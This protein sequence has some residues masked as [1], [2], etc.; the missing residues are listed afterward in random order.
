MS[1]S[2]AWWRKSDPAAADPPIEP[3]TDADADGAETDVDGKS[4]GEVIDDAIGDFDARLARLKDQLQ[5][6]RAEVVDL[7][8]EIKEAEKKQAKAFKEMLSANPMIRRMLKPRNKT[9]STGRRKRT[10]PETEDTPA[11]TDSLGESL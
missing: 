6:K 2:E 9:K 11:E 7:E 5:E 10:T 4:I 8:R 3:V 1:T